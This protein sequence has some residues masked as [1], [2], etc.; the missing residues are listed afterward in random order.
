MRTST[1]FRVPPLLFCSFTELQQC[2]SDQYAPPC[3]LDLEPCVAYGRMHPPLDA[4]FDALHSARRLQ[5]HIQGSAPVH[6]WPLSFASISPCPTVVHGTLPTTRICS[7][8]FLLF[9]PISAP[10]PPPLDAATRQ[11]SLPVT[12]G[13]SHFSPPSSRAF[14][15]PT[16][17]SSF[18]TAP[19]DLQPQAGVQASIGGGGIHALLTPRPSTGLVHARPPLV[20]QDFFWKVILG[21]QCL[22]HE[23]SRACQ[24]TPPWFYSII[25]LKTGL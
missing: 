6:Q 9:P 17:S 13:A 12:S 20:L 5:P 14:I 7:A 22:S 11:R 16:T 1:L 19:Y 18:G 25:L 2:A 15:S 24:S 4:P 3:G 21:F 23:S 8:T 10:A